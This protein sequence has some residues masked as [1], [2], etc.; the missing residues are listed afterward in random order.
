MDAFI[1]KSGAEGEDKPGSSKA[2][3][4]GPVVEKV[5]DD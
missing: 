4:M 1:L 3:Q 5:G 2:G